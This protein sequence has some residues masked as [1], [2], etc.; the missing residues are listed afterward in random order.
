MLRSPRHITEVQVKIILCVLISKSLLVVEMRGDPTTA[1]YLLAQ[2]KKNLPFC[3]QKNHNK[4]NLVIE[5]S[6]AIPDIV[7]ARVTVKQV[8]LL[9]E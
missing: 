7:T 3:H 9:A 2:Q 8:T 1:L 5:K 4:S 6:D